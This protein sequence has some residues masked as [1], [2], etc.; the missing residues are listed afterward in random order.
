M[1]S[2]LKDRKI[3]TK[4]DNSI[5]KLHSVKFGV[6]QGSVLGLLFFLLYVN[7]LPEASHFETTL[8]ADDT[9]LH[10][11]HS[12]V[13]TLQVQVSLEMK[14]IENWISKNKLTINYKKCAFMV[15]SNTSN[16]NS[17]FQISINHNLIDR[18]KGAFRLDAKQPKFDVINSSRK[19]ATGRNLREQLRNS[20][21]L[22]AVVR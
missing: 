17:D 18:T 6:P 3:C 22:Q 16:P 11:S 20:A 9:N 7:D 10:L 4:V 15:I 2:Y 12:N 14:N 1:N 21:C 5:S 13:K 8:F 19:I